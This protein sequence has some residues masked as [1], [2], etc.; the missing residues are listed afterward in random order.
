M[1]PAIC[2]RLAAA[3]LMGA[4]ATPVIAGRLE[5]WGI[6][7]GATEDGAAASG[8]IAAS[9]IRGAKPPANPAGTANGS[10]KSWG[11]V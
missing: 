7:A 10:A 4:G 5:V 2:S 11:N 3:A 6:G 9:A 8:W 1:T